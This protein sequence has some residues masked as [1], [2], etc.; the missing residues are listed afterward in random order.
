MGA[1]YVGASYVGKYKCLLSYIS[2]GAALFCL[3]TCLSHSSLSLLYQ[4]SGLRQ[5]AT[6]VVG[7]SSQW[8]KSSGKYESTGGRWQAT[9]ALGK[10]DVFPKYGDL[11]KAWA[12][13]DKAGK[14]WIEVCQRLDK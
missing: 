1:S 6:R 2:G 5:W 8:Q 12:S 14:E 7:V 13:K 3:H 9:Q 10:P 11:D 4:A